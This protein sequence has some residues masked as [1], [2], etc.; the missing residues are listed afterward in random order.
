MCRPR[1]N[2]NAII[3]ST[4]GFLCK[5]IC[6]LFVLNANFAFKVKSNNLWI[7]A[8]NSE[9]KNWNKVMFCTFRVECLS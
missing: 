5:M 3:S 7:A 9:K 2:A 8:I 1:P 6:W 4:S